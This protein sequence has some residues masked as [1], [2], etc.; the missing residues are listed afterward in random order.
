MGLS[1]IKDN[2]QLRE[3]QQL[4]KIQVLNFTRKLAVTFILTWVT[5]DSL[6]LAQNFSVN[7]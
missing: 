1:Q 3:F 5:N 6:L 4:L 7:L 2:A